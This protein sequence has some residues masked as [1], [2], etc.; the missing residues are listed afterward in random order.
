MPDK[1]QISGPPLDVVGRSAIVQPCVICLRPATQRCDLKSTAY[2]DRRVV[3][4][5]W[6]DECTKYVNDRG[7]WSRLNAKLT[8]DAGAQDL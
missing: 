7:E 3:T 4:T 8:R 5:F 1:N 6:C 2:A